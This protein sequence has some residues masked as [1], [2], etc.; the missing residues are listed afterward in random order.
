MIT[1][2]LDRQ[3]Y[4][5]EEVHNATL[6]VDIADSTSS[7]VVVRLGGQA[8]ADQIDI[9]EQQLEWAVR[10]DPRFVIL[11]LAGL[12]S[13]SPAALSSLVEFRWQ[14]CRQG[15]EV[16]L[17]GLQPSVWLAFQSN[18]LDKLFVI[19]DSVAQVFGR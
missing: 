12:A 18:R 9:L 4:Q 7:I 10:G 19:R 1:S 6:T 13:I 14:R 17:A 3:A 15:S 2:Q 11:D 8:D 5:S 16:W